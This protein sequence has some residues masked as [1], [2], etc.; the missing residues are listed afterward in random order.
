MDA[1]TVKELMK[2]QLET[3]RKSKLCAAFGWEIE[4]KDLCAHVMLRPRHC[5]DRGFLL[6]MLFD[7][8]PRRPPSYVFVD[9]TTREMKDEAWPPGVR[10]SAAP[11]GICTLGTRE[12][13]ENYHL[14]DAQYAWESQPNA[15]LTTLAEIHRLMERGIPRNQ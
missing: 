6:R 12:C 4:E 14:N 7:D 10:H 5:R 2:E 9:A 8:F 3:V 13:H 1:V 11:P 15:V